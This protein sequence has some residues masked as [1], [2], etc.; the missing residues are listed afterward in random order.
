MRLP[1]SNTPADSAIISGVMSV[2]S[3][4]TAPR[5]SR[6]KSLRWRRTDLIR[7][8][9]ELHVVA[10]EIFHGAPS[11]GAIDVDNFAVDHVACHRFRQ[12]EARKADGRRRTAL[13]F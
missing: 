7:L 6:W 13:T 11:L 9:D 1:N 5:S 8:P 4:R 12:E 3:T 2:I 10:R